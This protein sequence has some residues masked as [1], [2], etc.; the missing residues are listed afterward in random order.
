MKI[1]LFAHGNKWVEFVVMGGLEIVLVLSKTMFDDFYSI[2][3][4]CDKVRKVSFI[5]C[6]NRLKMD[7]SQSRGIVLWSHQRCHWWGWDYLLI[8]VY[9]LSDTHSSWGYNDV[10]TLLS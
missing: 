1:I 6:V 3:F 5:S 10:Q 7:V 9:I 8:A 4:K 2:S